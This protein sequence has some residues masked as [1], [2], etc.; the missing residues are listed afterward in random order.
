MGA[1]TI[2]AKA[3]RN[4]R[5]LFEDRREGLHLATEFAGVRQPV[6][7]RPTTETGGSISQDGKATASPR[8][9][10]GDHPVNPS[11]NQSEDEFEELKLH[12]ARAVWQKR[13]HLT[14]SGIKWGDWFTNKFGISLHQFRETLRKAKT[15]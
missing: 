10:S 15:V 7:Q 1:R 11:R 8:S 2:A 5:G 13:E 6:R 9:R 12:A 3:G 4:Q 14:P